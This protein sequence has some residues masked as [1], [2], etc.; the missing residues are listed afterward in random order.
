MSDDD[1][2]ETLAIT[3][4]FDPET[5]ERLDAFCRTARF[6]PNRSQAIREFVERGL[7]NEG[8]ETLDITAP[9][10]VEMSVRQDGKVV[11]VNVDG[12]C[13]FR[14]CQIEQ[15]ILEDHRGEVT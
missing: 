14:A 9:Q 2:T 15:L 1:D 7:A 10:V 5:I 8:K 13:R 12:I 3:I 4:R 6:R 11:W